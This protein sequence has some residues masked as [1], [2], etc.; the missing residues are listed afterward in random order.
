[1]TERLAKTNEPV[2][3]STV[4]SRSLESV[5]DQDLDEFFDVNENIGQQ[6]VP[7]S[8]VSTQVT[9]D[10][11]GEPLERDQL[12]WLKDPATK[13]SLWSVVKDSMNMKG[14]FFR[15]TLPVY[16][17]DPTSVLQKSAQ[18]Q[19]YA[20]LLDMAAIENDPIK[21]LAL[22]AVYTV[23]VQTVAEKSITKPFNPLLGETFEMETDNF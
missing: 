16:F 3:E 19:E 15:M 11:F 1:M 5:S 17:N 8:K 23:T 12:P 22:V 9:L 6:I 21:R 2:Y 20:Y 7:V 4:R 10:E 14:D 13:H 18:S